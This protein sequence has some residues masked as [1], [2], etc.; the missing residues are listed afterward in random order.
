DSFKQDEEL[1]MEKV[2]RHEL[3][4]PSGSPITMGEVVRKVSDATQQKAILVTDVGQNQ[5]EAV[6]YF[7]FE[8]KRSVVTSGGAGTM[9]FG[10]PAAIGAKI[11]KPNRTVCLF[12]GDGGFQMTMQEL[13]TIIQE[14]LDIKIIL[15]NN[16]YLGM[17]R[18]WQELFYNQRYSSTPMV[19]P[20]FV[21]IANAY[22][23]P[24][25]MVSQREELDDA[26][27]D[28][29]NSTNSYLLVVN[30]QEK[31]LVYPMT[32]AG[33]AVTTILLNENNK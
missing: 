28:M 24:T 16:N 10:I 6:R 26:I 1:E 5:M 29:I 15:M 22:N 21:A 32:P 8:E 7:Q 9:G 3:N 30:V 17:V 23:I 31:S 12:S 2:I 20:D 27:A 14:N 13:G 33:G 25:R 19:N 11:A 4:P 18:Q